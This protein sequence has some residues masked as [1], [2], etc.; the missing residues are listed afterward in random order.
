MAGDILPDTS[1]SLTDDERERLAC[2][3]SD[4]R[5]DYGVS[6]DENVRRHE[7]AAFAA[8]WKARNNEPGG[9]GGDSR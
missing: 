2:D 5:S 8:G 3:W 6:A 1:R 4:Y 9:Q 7:Y